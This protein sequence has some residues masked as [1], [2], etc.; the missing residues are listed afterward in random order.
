M[1][2]IFRDEKLIER[3]AAMAPAFAD[4]MHALADAPGVIDVRSI[5]V[6]AGIEVQA[7]GAPGARG[8]QL[9][10]A[11]FDRG[12]HL[13]S[14]GDTLIVAPA[15]IAEPTHIDEIT[16]KIRQALVAVRSLP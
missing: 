1:M 10:K 15:F 9:Q 13:K 5:G 14:T 6:M 3:A 2:D 11:L 4:A 7:V 8:H 16:T 12:L